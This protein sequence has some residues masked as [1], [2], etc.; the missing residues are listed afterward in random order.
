MQPLHTVAEPKQNHPRHGGKE[1]AA[2]RYQQH[3]LPLT[4]AKPIIP[5]R[6]QHKRKPTDQQEQQAKHVGDLHA[7][8]RQW[9]TASYGQHQPP[10]ALFTAGIHPQRIHHRVAQGDISGIDGTPMDSWGQRHRHH[11]GHQGTCIDDST[12]A[13]Q[14]GIV[15]KVAQQ[16][17][18][19]PQNEYRRCSKW[20]EV[21]IWILPGGSKP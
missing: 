15:Q 21:Q 1:Y 12:V 8:P 2:G 17:S 18:P 3:A 4:H 5:S 20:V 7:N 19:T 10:P 16:K 11:A 13:S 6:R 9:G 14:P